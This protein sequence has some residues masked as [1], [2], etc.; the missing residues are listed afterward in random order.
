MFEAWKAGRDISEEAADLFRSKQMRME[1]SE[2]VSYTFPFANLHTHSASRYFEQRRAA[3]KSVWEVIVGENLNFRT[4]ESC[5]ATVHTVRQ[6]WADV[7]ERKKAKRWKFTE[8]KLCIVLLSFEVS[9]QWG[10]G[11]HRKTGT[12]EDAA[13]DLMFSF[14]FVLPFAYQLYHA[15]VR[16]STTTLTDLSQEKVPVWV[17]FDSLQRSAC[18]PPAN[19]ISFSSEQ[20]SSLDS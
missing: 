14:I 6:G 9:H 16:A 11:Y 7:L 2:Q 5:S 20:S 13:E 18:P 3:F 1:G 10:L 15:C 8:S 19:H 17:V 12:L 4:W